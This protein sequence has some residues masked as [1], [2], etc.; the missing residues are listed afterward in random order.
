MKIVFRVDASSTIGTGHVVRCLTLAKALHER[1]VEVSFICREHDGHLCELITKNSYTVNRLP[2]H[3]TSFK[4]ENT[5]AHSAWLG[6]KWEV[7]A[8]ET[9]AV[10]ETMGD[11]P[12]WLIVDH[13]AIGSRW[14]SVLRTFVQRIMV[15][16]DLAD[17]EHDCDLLLDQNLVAEMHTR[18]VNKIS[19][20]CGI[21]LGPSY[22]L[23]QSIY[24]EMYNHVLPRKGPIRRIFIFFSGTSN[25]ILTEQAIAVFLSLNR[26]DIEVDVVVPYSQLE[27]IRERV[28]NC[29]NIYLHSALSTLA[30]LIAKA[31]LAIGA[32]GAASWER[33]CLGLPTLAVSLAENQRPIAEEL[34]RQG[35]IHYLG[36]IDTVDSIII[37]QELKKLVQQDLDENWSV[38]CAAKVDGKGANR[39]CTILMVTSKTPLI[40]RN[41][42]LK[43]EAFLLEW[44][45]DQTTRQNGFSF[46]KIS[47]ET[48][49]NWFRSRLSNLERFRFYIV[50]TEDGLPIGQVRFERQ[51]AV[52]EIHY[53]LALVF[54]KRGLGRCLLNTAMQKLRDEHVKALI[55]GRVKEGNLS[56]RKV[57]ES[58]GFDEMSDLSNMVVQYWREL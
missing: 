40:A 46:E 30:P 3:C 28:V 53:S 36:N 14:E 56:S 13:Y 5:L 8:S 19:A 26:P 33:L 47:V 38:R 37:A 1:N 50:E 22:A 11:K 24:E 31:D 39:V 49:R 35:L 51:G 48:H 10:I 15:I 27:S 7:D 54:R 32:S 58:L 44:A 21:L 2:V 16:D 45:N 25:N 34:D 29:P 52:W 9:K 43:D 23:L 4:T 12:D 18:Y 6:T 20:S 42:G 57:F 17:R 55:F 41:A